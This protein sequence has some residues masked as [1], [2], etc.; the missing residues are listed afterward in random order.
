MK[1]FGKS[2]ALSEWLTSHHQMFLAMKFMI[3]LLTIALLHVHGGVLSQNVTLSA[4]NLPLK[5]VF[6]E[7]EKQTGYIFFCNT[8]LFELAR[9]VNLS[10]KD[11][12]LSQAL[13]VC[14]LDEP[15]TYYIQNK[16]IFVSERLT[17]PV[18][19]RTTPATLPQRPGR[20]FP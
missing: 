11:V 9:P 13:E 6:R 12:P 18:N 5:K 1:V 10:V 15:L 2:H 19:N 4:H 14:F 7:I 3:V 20:T 8:A 16:T 17:T